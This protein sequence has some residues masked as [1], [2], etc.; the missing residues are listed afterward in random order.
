MSEASMMNRA[1]TY[2]YRR[3]R[4][5][6]L[7]MLL[8]PLLW[9]VVVYLGSLASMLLNSFFYLDGFTGKVVRQFTLQTYIKLLE[10]TNLQIFARTTIMAALV[11]VVC[12]IISFP[13]AY[14]MAR[15][16]SPR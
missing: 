5:L 2:L 10:P 12:I 4:L 15:H 14:Y 11:T 3:P 13:L 6:L 9:F 1:S 8:P 7:I 16:A